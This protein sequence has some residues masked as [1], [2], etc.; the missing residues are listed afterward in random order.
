MP[1]CSPWPAAI[2]SPSAAA[3][4]FVDACSAEKPERGATEKTSAISKILKIC[5]IQ[6]NNFAGAINPPNNHEVPKSCAKL[7]DREIFHKRFLSRKYDSYEF[8]FWPLASLL[9]P[10][11]SNT[12]MLHKP[13]KKRPAEPA[14][15]KARGCFR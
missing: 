15:F 8:Y 1:L 10:P 12:K 7:P 2:A 4:W 11:F 5:I 13:D 14:C 9:L 6:N 3:T